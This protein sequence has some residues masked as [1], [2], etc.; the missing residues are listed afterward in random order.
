MLEPRL[1]SKLN[2]E[3]CS[4]RLV[5]QVLSVNSAFLCGCRI[6]IPP[7]DVEFAITFQA[8]A[9]GTP[10]RRHA[11]RVSFSLSESA[12]E[13]ETQ[14]STAASWLAGWCLLHSGQEG[15]QM[16]SVAAATPAKARRLSVAN[17][18]FWTIE[19]SL[20]KIFLIF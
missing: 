5:S 11:A 4:P 10:Q 12:A 3:G 6:A 2:E 18:I 17:S 7:W 1:V 9:W 13:H 14:K 8:W 19:I 20:P 15:G 16:R